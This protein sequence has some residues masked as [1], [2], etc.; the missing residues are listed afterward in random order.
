MSISFASLEKIRITDLIDG[1]LEKFGVREHVHPEE[2]NDQQKCLT[3]GRNC[4]WVY[5]EPDGLVSVMTRY[6]GNAP[7]KILGAI[8]EAFETKIVSKHDPR[9]WGFDTQEE[10]D[11]VCEAISKERED[12]FYLDVLNYVSNQPND[13]KP[14]TIG[15]IQAKIAKQ[16]VEADPTLV[17][18]ER[19][20]DLMKGMDE[21]Y[22]RDHKIIVRLNEQDIAMAEMMVTHESDLPQA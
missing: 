17:L 22:D 21:V 2:T 10:W 18:P 19:R 4:L 16:L 5:G 6:A 7:G 11:A 8:A 15:E 1:R 9:F 12:Q 14:G 3:D 13:I 20:E